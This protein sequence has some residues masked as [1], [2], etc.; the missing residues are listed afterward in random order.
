MCTSISISCEE[1]MFKCLFTLA[2]SV[3]TFSNWKS[4]S[5]H[6]LQATSRRHLHQILW[7]SK[8]IHIE[9]ENAT[10]HAA[11][12]EHCCSPPLLPACNQHHQYELSGVWSLESGGWWQHS[13]PPPLGSPAACCSPVCQTQYNKTSYPQ[14]R[15]YLTLVLWRDTGTTTDTI[16]GF[17][18]SIRIRYLIYILFIVYVIFVVTISWQCWSVYC[19]MPEEGWINPKYC[20]S[21]QIIG[22]DKIDFNHYLASV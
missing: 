6:I 15:P 19:K 1:T 12:Q 2:F 22:E 3:L 8:S 21:C 17:I 10:Y 5:R 18:L 7:I 9:L 11:M 14:Q 4:T 16:L 13:L 20:L